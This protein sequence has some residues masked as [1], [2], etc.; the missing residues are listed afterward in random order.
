MVTGTET[1]LA[2]QHPAKLRHGGDKAKLIS[3]NDTS[4]YTFRGR[5]LEAD[6]A[7]TVAFE[8]T[9][10]AHNALRWLIQNQA[11]RSGD[12]AI[13]SWAVSG[14]PLPN[15]LDSTLELFGQ[16]A[17][18]D[19]AVP[20]ETAQAFARRLAS[21]I[22]GY[23]AKLDPAEDV[24]VIGMESATPGRMGITFYRELR[25]SEF[26]ERIEA[27]H[28]QYAWPQNFGKDARFIGTPAPRD[29]AEAAF[30]VARVRSDEKLRKATAER[31]L[32]CII[33]GARLPRGLVESTTRRASNRAGLDN[34][35]W[36]KVLG[37]ACGLFKGHHVERNYQM[38]LEP[39]RKSRDYLY[40]RLLAVADNL[41]KYALD[42]AGEKRDTTAARLMQRFAD[43]PASTW[44][45]IELALRPSMTRLRGG[46][47]VRRI[48]G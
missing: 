12:Q 34:W 25:G 8:V 42:M 35:E 18:G 6:E 3:S 9:Q 2:V 46:E 38:A 39:D 48:P 1:S 41:E 27:W 32:P 7:A 20:A 16:A 29:I 37:I 30:G 23:G 10:K 40:G 24:V 26:L 45:T 21:A 4:G 43:R 36:E 13:V 19:D 22:R 28:S 33:E 14:K 5:F 15:P 17:A 11:Y 47:Q 44:R 31:L